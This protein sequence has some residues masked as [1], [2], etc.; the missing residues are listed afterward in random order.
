LWL[1]MRQRRRPPHR[2]LLHQLL[3]GEADVAG[4]LLEVVRP[5]EDG[6]ALSLRLQYRPIAGFLWC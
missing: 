2:L 5:P 4:R 6:E 1:R 3:R